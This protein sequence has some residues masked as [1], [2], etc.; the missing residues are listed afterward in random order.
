MFRMSIRNKIFAYYIRAKFS[1][2]THKKMF[3]MFDTN[4]IFF[5][6]ILE[7]NSLI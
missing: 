4:K 3:R 1:K 6:I 5:R 2:I 7:Q